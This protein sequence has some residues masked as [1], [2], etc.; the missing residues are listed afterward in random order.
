MTAAD[1]LPLSRVKNELGIPL[2]E[3]EEDIYLEGLIEA[4]VGH[5]V[6]YTGR[7]LVMAR[8]RYRTYPAD[9]SSPVLLAVTDAIGAA[10]PGGT[11]TLALE[12]VSGGY[13]VR[14]PAGGWTTDADGSVQLDVTRHLPAPGTLVQ[15]AVIAL[16]LL[17]D[18]FPFK[19][20]NAFQALA[21]PWRSQIRPD[22]PMQTLSAPP[23]GHVDFHFGL[24]EDRDPLISEFT[25]RSSGG[26]VTIPA[27]DG[28]RYWMIARLA[29]EPE[30]ASVEVGTIG[31][32]NQ[33]NNF[34]LSPTSVRL[35]TGSALYSVLISNRALTLDTPTVLRAR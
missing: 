32:F 25:L 29:S 31:L 8:E 28:E 26:Q 27:Y 18:G 19:P 35:G 5:V 15:A 1:I 16:R 34:T 21:D 4:A 14:P 30:I 12:G 13:G 11:D 7:A 6:A 24:S 23:A 17:Y 20:N 10:V 22:R 9:P 2:T 33:R 3:T